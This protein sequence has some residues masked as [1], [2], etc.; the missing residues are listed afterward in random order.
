MDV[1]TSTLNIVTTTEVKE[2]SHL[3]FNCQGIG[4]YLDYP[5][6]NRSTIFLEDGEREKN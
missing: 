1:H 4:E 3:F 2:V 5:A 6:N